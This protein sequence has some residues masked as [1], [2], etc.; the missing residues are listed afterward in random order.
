MECRVKYKI[1]KSKQP[2]EDMTHVVMYYKESAHGC[3]SGRLFKGTKKQCEDF[4]SERKATQRARILKYL[5]EHG[6][7]TNR[8]C[9][10][11]LD[12]WDLQKSIQI[13]RDEGYPITD[14][15][16]QKANGKGHYKKYKLEV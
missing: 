9:G 2:E 4:L 11:E 14:E 13:L 12:I 16:I 10:Y 1:E 5:V 8:E 3:G 15:W 7:I 6:T